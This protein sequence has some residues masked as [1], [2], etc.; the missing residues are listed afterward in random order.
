M[1]ARKHRQSIED[2]LRAFC[3]EFTGR[4]TDWH[5]ETWYHPVTKTVEAAVVAREFEKLARTAR[6]SVVLEYLQ[7]HLPREPFLSVSLVKALTPHEYEETDWAP[8]YPT[9]SLSAP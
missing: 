4:D 1:N 2:G 9:L 6:T 3:R 8:S 7:T 5:V